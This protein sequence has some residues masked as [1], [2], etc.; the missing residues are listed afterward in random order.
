MQLLSK[1]QIQRESSEERR[2]Q[3]EEGAKLARKV[4]ELRQ[5]Q[6]TE[7]VNLQ[8]FKEGTLEQLS[9]E[10]G[11]L[12]EQKN[13]LK[14]EVYSLTL[15]KAELLVPLDEEWIKVTNKS[16]ELKQIENSLQEA[17]YKL[18]VKE[19]EIE[20]KAKEIATE[21]SRIKDSKELT[22][23]HLIEAENLMEQSKQGLSNAEKE[24][25]R[26]INEATEINRKSLAKEADIL[27]KE[28]YILRREYFINEKEKELSQKERLI[29]DR[30]ETLLRTI[31]RTK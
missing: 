12:T 3:I 10:I 14:D 25:N 31:K 17:T 7:Q 30:Y 26:L 2:R 11:A 5:A 13:K 16:N 19:S 20:N 23:K 21:D 29:N 18:K 28:D 4:D 9:K 15:R 1:N 6:F 22:Q 24:A 8:K 27:F